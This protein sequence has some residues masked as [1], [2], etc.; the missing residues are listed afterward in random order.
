MASIAARSAAQAL[1][2]SAKQAARPLVQSA[3]YSLLARAAV[4]RATVAAVPAV[5]VRVFHITTLASI[6]HT[7][8]TDSWCQDS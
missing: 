2:R 1:R 4:N 3:K 8:I 6:S 7:L 5:Q